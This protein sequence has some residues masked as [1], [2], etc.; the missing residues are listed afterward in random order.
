MSIA[1]NTDWE[2]RTTGVSTNGGGFKDLDPGV[3]VDY[4][5]QDAAQLALTDISITTNDL[6]SVTG[7]F[8]A[9]MVGNVIFL[10]SGGATT[11]WY[12]ITG[13]TDTNNIEVDRNPGNGSGTTGN[14]GGAWKFDP[15]YFNTFFSST[16]KANYDIVHVKSGTYTNFGTSGANT[17][18]ASYQRMRGYTTSRGDQP[19]GADRPY[20]ETGNNASYLYWTG[21]YGQMEHIRVDST[22]SGSTTSTLSNTGIFFIIR[23]CKI[24]RSGFTNCMAYRMQ[25]DYSRAIQCEF[26]ATGGYGV[27]ITNEHCLVEWCY[28][29]DCKDGINYSSSNAQ[30]AIVKNCIIDTCSQFGI[31]LYF[32]ALVT[33]TTVYNCG[34]GIRV[35]SF[36]SFV[37]NTIIHTCTTGLYATEAAYSDNNCFYNNTTDYDFGVVAGPNDI[38]TDPL[39]VNPANQDFTL[40]A[41]SPAFNTGI[42]LGAAVGLP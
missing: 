36:Y 4:S 1:A 12:Q 23:N 34:I 6:T 17:I 5:Q 7:G 31:A 28:V 8:T 11:G 21:Q 15:T 32:G 41:A 25:G 37:V 20:F 30:G 42:K 33:D 13:Y 10:E 3:S 24:T 14:V 18:S 19:I 39:L 26:E 2:I 22:Y 27:Q 35:S 29:H 9:A 40:G 38:A 16:N